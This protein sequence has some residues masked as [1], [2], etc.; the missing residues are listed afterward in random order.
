MQ[1][2]FYKK[3]ELGKINQAEYRRHRRSCEICDA[4]LQQDEKLLEISTSLNQKVEAPLLWAKIENQL[5]EQQHWEKSPSIDIK[6]YLA[7]HK[8]VLF[9]LA[10]ILVLTVGIAAY[11]LSQTEPVENLRI[12]TTSALQKVEQKEREYEKAIGDLEKL[13]ESKFSKLD[14]DLMLLYRDRLETIE[15][16]IERCKEALAENPGNAHIRRYLLA[17]L[18]DKRDTLQEVAVFDAQAMIN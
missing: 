13:V 17:A 7:S 18:Q 15:S 3:H 16:Q 11:F 9:R 12:L 6:K 2:D 10:A 1:C 8:T 4:L 5:R 14:I